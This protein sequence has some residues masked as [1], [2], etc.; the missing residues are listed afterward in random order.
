MRQNVHLHTHTHTDGGVTTCVCVCLSFLPADN[1]NPIAHDISRKKTNS[2]SDW[3]V[4]CIKYK[5]ATTTAKW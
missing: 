1:P 5:M 3:I 4:I 2:K